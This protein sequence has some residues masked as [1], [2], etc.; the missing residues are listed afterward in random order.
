MK[1]KS[2]VLLCLLIF[3][4]LIAYY[5]YQKNKNEEFVRWGDSIHTVNTEKL[6]E[7]DIEYKIENDKVYIPKSSLRKATFCCS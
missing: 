6:K 5:F 2:I 4:M 3:S 1:K 7:N